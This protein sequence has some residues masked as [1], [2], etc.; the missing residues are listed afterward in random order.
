MRRGLLLL[1]VGGLSLA[2]AAAGVPRIEFMA[3]IL[4]LGIVRP[5]SVT[6]GRFV[7][8]NTGDAP[9][10][11]LD[12]IA[13]CGCTVIRLSDRVVPPGGQVHLSITFTASNKQGEASKHI[14]LITDDP[15]TPKTKLIVQASVKGDLEW[16]PQTFTLD[17]PVAPDFQGRI[18]FRAAD[19]IVPSRVFD[20][21]GFL[22]TEWR[23]LPGEGWEVEFRLPDGAEIRGVTTVCVESNSGDFPL[24][25]VPVYFQKASLL[26]L[27]PTRTSF[28]VREGEPAPVRRITIARR[29]GRPLK[30]LRVEP[31]R[32]YLVV[33]VIQVAG[34]AAVIEV[35]LQSGLSMGPCD[36]Y[37][38]IVT[39]A[40]ELNLNIPCKVVRP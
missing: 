30:V 29:D 12:V 5:G 38:H 13:H 3:E 9:L 33:K 36:G 39:D 35:T 28:Y 40:E 25:K 20:S 19:G 10:R 18:V 16:S 17:W 14:D 27:T 11:I 21:T 37:L 4:D 31:S 24:V 1:L 15:V 8:L 6:P 2:Y 26:R 34:E 22:R 7:I 23:P 32:D